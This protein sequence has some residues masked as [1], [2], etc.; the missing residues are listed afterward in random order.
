MPTEVT[1]L[2]IFIA[3]IGVA[4][5][6]FACIFLVGL[7]LGPLGILVILGGAVVRSRAAMIVG[8]VMMSGPLLY[9]CLALAQ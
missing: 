5:S 2:T 4:V 1:G 6:F 7:L 8:G 3:L 9:V